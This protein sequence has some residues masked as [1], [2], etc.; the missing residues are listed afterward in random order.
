MNSN[1]LTRIQQLDDYQ[2][3]RFLQ[4]F[5]DELFHG[6]QVTGEQLQA[7]VPDTVRALPA[8]RA[9]TELT[10]EAKEAALDPEDAGQVAQAI[11][12]VMAQDEALV[13]ALEAAMDEYRDDAL[14]ADVI[15]AA[16]F[17]AS[18]IIM[19]A[20]TS[21]TATFKNVKIG[22]ETASAEL[23]GKVAELVG[24]VSEAITG[25]GG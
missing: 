10:P 19:A 12:E 2:A 13:P 16:G 4:S 20:T 11:L 23:V 22:K 7:S 5:G 17:A 9:I 15:L 6:L 1:L 24:R 25:A 3:V 18:M 8:Y 14:V 21:F